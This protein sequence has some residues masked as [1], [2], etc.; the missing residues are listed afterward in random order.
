[1]YSLLFRAQWRPGR[2]SFWARK[3]VKIV[4]GAEGL[5]GATRTG[6]GLTPSIKSKMDFTG[7]DRSVGRLSQSQKT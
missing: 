1:M 7:A 2:L 5:F 4:T 6:Q 3:T